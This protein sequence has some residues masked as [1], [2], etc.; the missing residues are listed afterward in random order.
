MGPFLNNPLFLHL[1]NFTIFVAGLISNCCNMRQWFWW[2]AII[3]DACTIRIAV[4]VEAYPFAWG[5]LE[6]LF[7]ASG[8]TIVQAEE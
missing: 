7:K 3:D 5:S 6:W 2:D 1:Y 8:A 4:E